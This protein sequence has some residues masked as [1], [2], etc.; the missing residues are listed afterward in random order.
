MPADAEKVCLL[1]WIGS[2]GEKP[3]GAVDAFDGVNAGRGFGVIVFGQAVDLL[4]IKDR[5]A[6]EERN[7]V[8]GFLAR[9]S[10]GLGA[11]DLV[12]IDDEAAVLALADMAFSSVACLYVIQTGAA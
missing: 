12:G 5:V 4:D 3:L 8:F 11:D 10:V 7:C 6:L 2:G 9:R 1:G